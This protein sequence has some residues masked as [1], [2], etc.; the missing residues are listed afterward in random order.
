[1]KQ[2]IVFLALMFIFVFIL[3]QW[4]SNETSHM[5]RNTLFNIV[6]SHAQDAR[7]EGYFTPT[8][9]NSL[10][11]DINSKMGI[12]ESEIRITVTDTPKYRQSTFDANELISYKVEVPI[13]NVIAMSQFFGISNQDNQYWFPVEG[14]VTSERLIGR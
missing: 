7:K 12:S 9:I 3:L 6:E 10:K 4:T 5:K 2:F 14:K 1:M 13:K 8:N 11:S